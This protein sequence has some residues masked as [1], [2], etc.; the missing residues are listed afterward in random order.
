[1][2]ISVLIFDESTFAVEKMYS[3]TLKFLYIARDTE[4][5]HKHSYRV[6]CGD[7]DRAFFVGKERLHVRNS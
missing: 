4:A 5:I 3:C 2:P 6:I 7:L 1:V